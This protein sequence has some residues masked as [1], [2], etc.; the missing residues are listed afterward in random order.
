MALSS[1]QYSVD[2]TAVLI[3]VD[4]PSG[5]RVTVHNT[6]QGNAVYLNGSSSV[7]SVTGYRLDAKDKLQ[8]TLNASEQLWAICSSGQ[9][10]VVAVLRQTQY[11]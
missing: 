4:S 1:N 7:S 6:D 5:C 8:L 11:A 9:T 3:A 2:G 10:A